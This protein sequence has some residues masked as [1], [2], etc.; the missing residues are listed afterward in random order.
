M[1][2]PARTI[3]FVN[4]AHAL[5][6]YLMLI[7]PTAVL[8][9]AAETGLAYDRLIPLATGGLIAYGVLSLPVGWVADRLG[10]RRL[11]AAFFIGSGLASAAVATAQGPA[12]LAAALLALGAACAIYHPVGLSMLA[13]TSRR[14]GR[15]LGLNGVCGNLGA[16]G[17]AALTA[18]AAATLGWR[19]A[20]L[21]P[22][23]AAIACGLVYLATT[24]DAPAGRADGA[25]PAEAEPVARPG[26]AL[27]AAVLA[28]LAGGITY[29]LV[30]IAL[31]K[32]IDERAGADLTLAWTGT[33]ATAVLVCGA[34]M[35]L[36]VGTLIDRVALPTLLVL[37]AASQMTGLLIAALFTGPLL[38]LG[39]ALTMA[40]IYGEVVVDDALVARFVPA[41]LR[42]KAYGVSYFLGFTTAGVAAPLIGLTHAGG[43]FGPLLALTAACG[44]ALFLAAIG[45]RLAVGRRDV[46]A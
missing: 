7:Y 37:L 36:V 27:A 5:V 26:L 9:V 40:A 16:S 34:A 18:L 29:S 23:L 4:A 11:L 15:D 33:L 46:A 24:S 44:T 45:F 22:G 2:S 20:F 13:A 25:A 17:A 35:Q 8:A 43:G 1:S 41:A 42:S 21:L 14:L 12:G 31:P 10:P 30:T 32:I 38:L 39:L 3:A 28:I 19:A 6:H